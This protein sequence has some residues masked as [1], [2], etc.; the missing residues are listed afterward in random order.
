MS[1]DTEH[2][3][4]RGDDEVEQD[5][6]IVRIG[7]ERPGADQPEELAQFLT[8]RAS[9]MMQQGNHEEALLSA[10]EAVDIWRRL[11][12]ARPQAGRPV[13]AL[14]QGI[15]SSVLTAMERHADA[16]EG[17][18]GALR[19][20]APVLDK[21]P[22]PIVPLAASLMKDYLA[23]VDNAGLVPDHEL[24]GPIADVL[25]ASGFAE[26]ASDEPSAPPPFDPDLPRP[27]AAEP[28]KL[29]QYLLAQSRYLKGEEHFDGALEAIEEAVAVWHDLA[30]KKPEVVPMEALC[31]GLQG[32]ILRDLVRPADAAE[33][34]AEG[35]R[36]I[37]PMFM[38]NPRPVVSL[39]AALFRDYITAAGEAEMEIDEE[40]IEPVFDKL[41]AMGVISV[42]ESDDDEGAAND[43]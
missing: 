5:D 20:V 27:D 7:S 15:R 31:L 24:V 16:A 12:A 8:L 9:H 1:D 35:L 43:A 22:G 34:F 11:T 2:D 21:E 29:A 32:D 40:M 23:S 4:G 3:N 36:L 25:E 13:L 39:V 33:T 41:R 14:T 38:D 17:L 30:P 18:A 28:E 37:T 6:R 19:T 42:D 10:D 26:K